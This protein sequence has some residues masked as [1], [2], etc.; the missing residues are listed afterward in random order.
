MRFRHEALS[1]NAH[2][3]VNSYPESLLHA[4][5]A[6]QFALRQLERWT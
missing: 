1:N 2:P 3:G 4:G 5:C 6:S